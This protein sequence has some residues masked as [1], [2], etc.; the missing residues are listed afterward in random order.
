MFFV[1]LDAL[2]EYLKSSR[3]ICCGEHFEHSNDD[4]TVAINMTDIVRH[5]WQR[6]E[7]R[8]DIF[9]FLELLLE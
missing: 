6:S 7:R 3:D 4:L 9:P 5:G 2:L 1:G 8:F